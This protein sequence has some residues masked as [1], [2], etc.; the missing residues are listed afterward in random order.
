MPHEKC[1][2]EHEYF[3][4]DDV[5]SNSEEI[6]TDNQTKLIKHNIGQSSGAGQSSG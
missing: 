4:V 6:G 1:V 5:S 2:E 3:N